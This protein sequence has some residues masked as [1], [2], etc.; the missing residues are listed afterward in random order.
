MR[1]DSGCLLSGGG[2]P[3]VQS[4]ADA[5]A[6]RWIFDYDKTYEIVARDETRLQGIRVRDHTVQ[7]V[8]HVVVFEKLGDC[9]HM[10]RG[11]GLRV[12]TFGFRNGPAP[13][14]HRSVEG[15]VRG[16]DQW[17]SRHTIRDTHYFFRQRE[18][19]G[20]AGDNQQAVM[21]LA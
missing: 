6:L 10:A 20:L 7:H 21:G 11:P 3:L 15:R 4:A 12:S 8:C 1:T 16:T 5:A 9:Q 19:A 18:D 13:V 17:V 14:P 2:D